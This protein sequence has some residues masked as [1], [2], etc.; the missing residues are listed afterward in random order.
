MQPAPTPAM[1]L[2]QQRL[3]IARTEMQDCQ[4]SMKSRASAIHTGAICAE[5]KA[6]LT[7]LTATET[8]DLLTKVQQMDGLLTQNDIHKIL[9]MMAESA[10]VGVRRGMQDYTNL[11]NTFSDQQW[12]TTLLNKSVSWEG[13]KHA[14]LR[15]A[16]NLEC[17]TPSEP[18]KLAWAEFLCAVHHEVQYCMEKTKL[19]KSI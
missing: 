2:I 8:A 10:K 9:S 11:K 15:H 1:Q 5:L 4:P 7:M 18:T 17:H 19:R 14:I 12:S 6:N 3:Q 16:L 13:R